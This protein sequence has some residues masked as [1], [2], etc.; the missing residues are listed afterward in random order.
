MRRD[1]QRQA[2][3]AQPQYQRQ[4]YGRG[5]QPQTRQQP[6]PFT[7]QPQPPRKIRAVEDEPCEDDL[8]EQMEEET[9]EDIHY[10]EEDDYAYYEEEELVQDF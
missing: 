4:G 5:Y 9:E 10:L 2:F 1:T 8:V 6:R 7:R 3:P